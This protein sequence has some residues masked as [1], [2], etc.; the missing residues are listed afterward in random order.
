[1]KK[2]AF[3]ILL[4]LPFLLFSC[5]KDVTYENYFDSELYDSNYAAW[6]D[7]NLKDYT[8]TITSSHSSSSGV[9]YKVVVEVRNNSV[10]SK[11]YSAPGSLE[12]REEKYLQDMKAHPLFGETNSIDDVFD[13]I[14]K[15]YTDLVENPAPMSSYDSGTGISSEIYYDAV[16]CYVKYDSQYHYPTFI[17]FQRLYKQGIEADS[18]GFNNSSSYQITDFKILSDE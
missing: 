10:V 8:F 11:D 7:K 15:R 6:K 16:H 13:Y 1:M 18:V 17:K 12:H 2:T 9:R 4:M 14:L 3:I 5:I